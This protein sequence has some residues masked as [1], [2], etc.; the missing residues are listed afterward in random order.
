MPRALWPALQRRMVAH[1]LAQGREWRLPSD[2]IFTDPCFQRIAGLWDVA[3]ELGLPL[4]NGPPEV[5][6]LL[7]QHVV[8]D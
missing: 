1:T 4:V 2:V 6:N 5:V 7:L 8:R 3:V